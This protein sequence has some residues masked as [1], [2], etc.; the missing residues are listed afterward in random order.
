MRLLSDPLRRLALLLATGCG[1]DA[2]APVGNVER[3]T[4][5]PDYRTWYAETEACTGLQGNYDDIVWWLA[6]SLE[7]PHGSE[8]VT[9]TWT[10]PHTIVFRR[11]YQGD[12]WVVRHEMIHDL[13]QTTAHPSPPFRLCDNPR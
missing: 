5:P 12:V 7:A 11:G 6:D 8:L 2:F 4:P 1:G 13:L 9:G 10:A 3:F